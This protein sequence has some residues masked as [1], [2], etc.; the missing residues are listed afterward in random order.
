MSSQEV[1]LVATF[2]PKPGKTDELIA[3]MNDMAKKVHANEPD[4]LVYY[5]VQVEGKDEIIFVEKYA[6]PALGPFM[7]GQCTMQ[8]CDNQYRYK[9][10]AA[11]TAHIQTPYFQE[12][13]EKVSSLTEKPYDLK[14]GNRIAGFEGRTSS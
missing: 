1:N 8:R 9:N 13:A 6:D 11:V 3:L 5:A 7:Q 14:M 10:Q 2:Y 12:F 4:T